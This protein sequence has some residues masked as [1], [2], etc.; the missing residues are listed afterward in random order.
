MSGH[1]AH[2]DSNDP[3]QKRIAVAMAIYAVQLAFANMLTTQARTQ[4]I[5]LSNKAASK[6]SY[7]QSKGTK[8]NLAGAEVDILG[9]LPS[10]A[11]QAARTELIAKLKG[12][13]TRYETEKAA[14]QD[15]AKAFEVKSAHEEHKEHFC[16]YGAIAAELAIV[17]AGVALLMHSKK[18]L[19]ASIAMSVASVLILV[20]TQFLLH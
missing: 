3:F 1:G 12:E 16:E 14:I 20:Y 2:V 15:E 8:Q 6:W 19:A 9:Q 18:I 4:A 13:V 11:D 17:I 7:F 10:A 5:L